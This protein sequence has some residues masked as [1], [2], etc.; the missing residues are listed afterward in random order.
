MTSNEQTIE[1]SKI[2]VK[3]GRTVTLTL[4]E[5]EAWRRAAGLHVDP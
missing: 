3:Q 1:T 4:E 2:L 5:W